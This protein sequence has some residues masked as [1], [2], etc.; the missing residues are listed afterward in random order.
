MAFIAWDSYLN[1]LPLNR[2]TITGA[3]Y[4]LLL[5]PIEGRNCGKPANFAEKNSVRQ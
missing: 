4:P 2:K 1:S 3:F 5:D